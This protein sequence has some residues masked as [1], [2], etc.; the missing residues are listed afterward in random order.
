[1]GPKKTGKETN[2]RRRSK[3]GLV[4]RGI[5]TE[6]V[7]AE[8]KKSLVSKQITG[9]LKASQGRVERGEK[10]FKGT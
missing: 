10:I 6:E 4:L 5:I 2:R 7:D 1:L 3:R 9:S 8:S